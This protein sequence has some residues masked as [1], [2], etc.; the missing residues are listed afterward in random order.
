MSKK[1]K[2]TFLIV[3]HNKEIAAKTR[4]QLSMSNGVLSEK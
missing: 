4:R 3:T 2:V 1:K